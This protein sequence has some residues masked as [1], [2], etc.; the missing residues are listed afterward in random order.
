M[1]SIRAFWAL[2]DYI[3]RKVVGDGWLQLSDRISR[4]LSPQEGESV[5]LRTHAISLY[6]V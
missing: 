4:C 6:H 1:V 3:S 5:N 2:A